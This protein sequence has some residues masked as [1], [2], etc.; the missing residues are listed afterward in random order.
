MEILHDSTAVLNNL[1]N[2]LD[3]I[4]NKRNFFKIDLPVL[5]ISLVRFANVGTK[6]KLF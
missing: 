4:V 6:I 2:S 1:L 3:E 5:G